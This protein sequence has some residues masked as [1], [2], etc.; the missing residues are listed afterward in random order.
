MVWLYAPPGRAPVGVVT[1]AEDI[2]D[3]KHVFW[4]Y[5]RPWELLFK[6][7]TSIHSKI[8]G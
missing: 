1:G 5:F 3:T 7:K 6:L 4:R 8:E 2:V